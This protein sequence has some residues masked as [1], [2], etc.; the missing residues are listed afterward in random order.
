MLRHWPGWQFI[1]PHI[2]TDA[3]RRYSRVL[4]SRFAPAGGGRRWM[5]VLVGRS[6]MVFGIGVRAIGIVYA[7]GVLLRYG[8]G[9]S[10]GQVITVTVRA[11]AVADKLRHG[12]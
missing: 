1:Q 5:P 6:S 12:Q 7:V 9:R 8:S 11:S 2:A 3:G 4:R 10:T